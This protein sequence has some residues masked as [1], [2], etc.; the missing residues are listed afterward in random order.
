MTDDTQTEETNEHAR[1][2]TAVR[3]FYD[4]QTLRIQNGNRTSR[5]KSTLT[6]AEEAYFDKTKEGLEALERGALSEVK[7]ALKGVPIY[8]QWLTKQKGCGPTMSGLIVSEI[9]IHNGF[10]T[11]SKLWRYCGFA[12]INGKA[13]RRQ[14]GVK[15]AYN[16][17]L[18][19]KLGHVLGECLIR[20]NS[21]WR[22]FYDNYKTRKQNQHVSKCMACDGSGTVAFDTPKKDASHALRD[23]QKKPA[24]QIS[25]DTQSDLASLKSIDTHGLSASRC[26]NCGGD[27]GPAPW[28]KS[29][30]HRHNAAMRYMVKMFLLELWRVWRELEGLPVGETYAEAYLN[31][32]HGDHGGSLQAQ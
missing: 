12:V 4:L 5:T 1:I 20:A 2:R 13:E 3:F 8:E 19:A 24:S 26:K 21:P 28:G 14:K 23:N 18:K 32:R 17:W 11:P 29:D 15:A 25:P 7:R 6:K 9:D 16:P 10:E 31:R 27:G 22:E 30:A